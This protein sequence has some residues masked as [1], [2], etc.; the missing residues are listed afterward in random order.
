MSKFKKIIAFVICLMSVAAFVSGV[1]LYAKHNTHE[2]TR[3]HGSMRHVYS[4][5][6]S[7][8]E[9]ARVPDRSRG[10]AGRLGGRT[11]IISVFASDNSYRW[12][13][14]LPEDI[15]KMSNINSYLG[16]ATDYLSEQAAQYGVEADFVYDFTEN[17]DLAYYL[18]L[19]FYA[20]DDDSNVAEVAMNEF[21]DDNVDSM[22]LYHKYEADNIIYFMFFNTDADT[23]AITCTRNW[24][25][26]IEHPYEIVFL[27]YI[28]YGVVNCPAVY[29]HEMLH[30]YG[31]PDLYYADAEYG[32]TEEFLEYVTT[33]TPNDI[34]YYCSDI[35]TNQYVYNRVTNDLSELDAYYV[36]LIDECALVEEYGLSPSQHISE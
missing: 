11:L 9:A 16:T 20:T 3:R 5:M 29:A 30:A 6:M 10:S 28:D 23:S 32:I 21:L 25:R 12:D 1:L 27:F 34:M 14:N 24:Y 13:F 22:A 17:P 15:A 36:G 7:R 31:A 19:P 35:S 8:I 33:E 2:T 26:G 4:S 18:D